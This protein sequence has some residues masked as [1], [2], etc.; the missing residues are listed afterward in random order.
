MSTWIEVNGARVEKEFFEAN[1][2]EAKGYDWAET[3][4]ADLVE[5]IHCMI[6]GIT[7]DPATTILVY[8]SKGVHVCAYCHDHFLK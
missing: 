6:C 3:R 8:K 1:V 5:H 7:V 2:R 4:A